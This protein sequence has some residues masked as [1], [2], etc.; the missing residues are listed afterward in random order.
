MKFKML[1]NNSFNNMRHLVTSVIIVMALTL[2]CGCHRGGD[3]LK[4]FG[5]RKISSRVD[6]LT[7]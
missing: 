2:T 6:S 1:N 3:T 7:L 4:P 5:W